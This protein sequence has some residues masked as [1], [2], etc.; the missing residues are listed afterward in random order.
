MNE[1]A[2]MLKEA[3]LGAEPHPPDA[4]RAALERSIATFERRTRVVRAMT[5]FMLVACTIPFLGGLWFL[6]TAPADATPR[7]LV[8]A[9]CAFLFGAV[10]TGFGKGWYQVMQNHLALMKELKV[11]ELRALEAARREE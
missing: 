3:L 10:G 11:L 6:V 7:R 5:G 8:L 4:D 9:A 2:T 1:F